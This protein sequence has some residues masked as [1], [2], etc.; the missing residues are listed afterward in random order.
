M[1]AALLKT[2]VR[3]LLSE[4]LMLKLEESEAGDAQLLFGPNSLGLDSVDALQL[5]VALEKTYGLNISDA[6][7]VEKELCSVN[8]IAKAILRHKADIKSRERQFHLS[9][10]MF[11]LLDGK[12]SIAPPNSPLSHRDWLIHTPNF[13]QI[14]RGFKDSKGDVYFYQG[15]HFEASE[16]TIHTVSSVLGELGKQLQLRPDAKVYAGMKPGRIG[17]TW[18]PKQLLGKLADLTQVG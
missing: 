12:L 6:I 18:K 13:N 14:I 10:Q 15:E 2:E 3:K 5:V 7:V 11:Y 17:E 4:N 8:A 9:R 16:D 1:N